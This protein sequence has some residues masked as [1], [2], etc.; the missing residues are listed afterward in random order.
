MRYMRRVMERV[1]ML[2]M[3]ENFDGLKKFVDQ[4]FEKKLEMTK[5]EYMFFW[6]VS[7]FPRISAYE[8]RDAADLVEGCQDDKFHYVLSY[9]FERQEYYDPDCIGMDELVI[10]MY[11]DCIFLDMEESYFKAFM[12]R[13]FD[14]LRNRHPDKKDDIFHKRMLIAV[15]EGDFNK[16]LELMNLGGYTSH[17]V[18]DFLENEKN[19]FDDYGEAKEI[20]KL[21]AAIDFIYYGTEGHF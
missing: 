11:Y 17:E 10:E 6:Y 5:E 14:N 4:I 3:K 2:R 7:H 1:A 21:D 9:F 19:H 12:K 18:C 13:N 20:E 15:E 8:I 16:L